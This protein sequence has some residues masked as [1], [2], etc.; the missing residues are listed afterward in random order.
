M[1]A[2][3]GRRRSSLTSGLA[4]SAKLAGRLQPTACQHDGDAWTGTCV[5]SICMR[6]GIRWRRRPLQS[7]CQG[8]IDYQKAGHALFFRR[9]CLCGTFASAVHE[10]LRSTT[11][12]CGVAVVELACVGVPVQ[13]KRGAV[14]GGVGN[15]H[16]EHI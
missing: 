4:R 14:S 1:I 11:I 12:R 3:S 16:P 7:M 8:H 15:G 5:S 9:S 13:D 10:E 2:A 6:R